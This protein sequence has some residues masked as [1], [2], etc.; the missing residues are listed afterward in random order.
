MRLAAVQS[1]PEKESQ[2]L[3]SPPWLVAARLSRAATVENAQDYQQELG[4]LKQR[5]AALEKYN[6]EREKADKVAA[7]VAAERQAQEETNKRNAEKY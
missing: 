2:P 5:V 3:A 6:K 1:P 7:K 4:S